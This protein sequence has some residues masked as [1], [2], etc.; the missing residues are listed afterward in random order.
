MSSNDVQLD[1][2]RGSF[3]AL[4]NL[5]DKNRYRIWSAQYVDGKRH[6]PSPPAEEESTYQVFFD[7]AFS[8]FIPGSGFSGAVLC[9]SSDENGFSCR[10]ARDLETGYLLPTNLPATHNTITLTDF[11]KNFSGQTTDQNL[12]DAC[13]RYLDANV[14]RKVEPMFRIGQNSI[15]CHITPHI[16]ANENFLQS[17][18]DVVCF[19]IIFAFLGEYV[20]DISDSDLETLADAFLQ[21]TWT[22]TRKRDTVNLLNKLTSQYPSNWCFLISLPYNSFDTILSHVING[23][24]PYIDR[25]VRIMT[26]GELVFMQTVENLLSRE[27]THSAVA[28]KD[29]LQL[30]ENLGNSLLD[31]DV[32]ENIRLTPRR[33]LNDD[34]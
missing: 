15:F 27:K 30:I 28:K 32:K 8:G 18:C 6:L 2:L 9:E 21:P 10:I 24:V 13:T 19:E 31:E 1:K 33:G 3:E 16:E 26:T 25:N 34:K 4:K 23:N 22:N 11:I 29:A 17:F 5:R 14:D 12:K 7:R 20:A